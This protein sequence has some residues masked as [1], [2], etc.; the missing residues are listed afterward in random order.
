VANLVGIV[1]RDVALKL[2][3]A[4]IFIR[5]SD[6]APNLHN[7]HYWIDLVGCVATN[8]EGHSYGPVLEVFDNGAHPILRFDAVMIPFIDQFVKTVDTDQKTLTVDW[9]VEWLEAD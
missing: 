3:G 7:E 9:P 2:K 4:T 5:R 8:L 6:F 1:D